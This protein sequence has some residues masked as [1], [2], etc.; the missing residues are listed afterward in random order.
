MPTG[1]SP[2]TLSIWFRFASVPS[3]GSADHVPLMYGSS[4]GSHYFGIDIY[5]GSA[6][7][8]TCSSK[9]ILGDSTNL[10]GDDSINFTADT[11]W[12]FIA[13]TVPPGATSGSGA[14]IY[15]DGVLQPTICYTVAGTLNTSL[16]KT[17][18]GSRNYITPGTYFG[19]SLDNA[20][21]YNRALSAA[22]IAAMYNGRKVVKLF[23]R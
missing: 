16:S 18:I 20:R 9:S 4:G 22:Q 5:F 2:R 19:G 21:I 8:G 23:H 17:T 12:H 11:N 3:V 14:L 13:I 6:T 7:L 15:L 1:S 10:D